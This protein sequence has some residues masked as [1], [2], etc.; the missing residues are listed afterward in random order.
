[1]SIQQVRTAG[2]SLVGSAIVAGV[3]GGI[4]VDA[5][6]GVV[7]HKSPLD[8]WQFVASTLVGPVAY[9]SPAY[10]I[11]GGAMHFVISIVW[12]VIYLFVFGALGQ[13][14]NWILGAIVWGVVVDA[15]MNGL[16]AVK[17]GAPFVPAFTGGLLAHV[18]FYGLPVAWYIARKA[19]A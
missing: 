8:I 16:L 4:L 13:I 18:I 5:F 6:L 7:M 9:T 19:R 12:A 1:M 11:L 2:N 3:L 10:S 15:V 17:I 14:R